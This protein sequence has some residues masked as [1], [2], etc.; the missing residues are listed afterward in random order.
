MEASYI[1]LTTIVGVFLDAAIIG[2]IAEVL[3]DANT[4]QRAKSDFMD[5]VRG[6]GN[7][8]THTTCSKSSEPSKTLAV[9]TSI[10]DQWLNA[11]T[12]CAKAAENCNP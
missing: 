11:T 4:K 7:I 6:A 5:K 8:L 10:I 9:C 2:N 12:W 3:S 1:L